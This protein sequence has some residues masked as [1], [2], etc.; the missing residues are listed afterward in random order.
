MIDKLLDELSGSRWFSKLDLRIGYNQIRLALG[1]EYKTAFQTHCG[2]YEFCV[3]AF[4]L[5]NA[6]ATFQ[7]AMN[8]LLAPCFRKFAVVFLDDILIYS[9]SYEDN[10]SH[11]RAVL[12]ILE[13]DDTSQTYL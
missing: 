2:H 4:G 13:R 7:F 11:V 3:M 12:E 9:Q 1:E 5:T 6:L 10:L 8:A